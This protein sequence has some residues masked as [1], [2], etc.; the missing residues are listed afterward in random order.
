MAKRK[1]HSIRDSV[2]VDAAGILGIVFHPAMLLIGVTVCT[3][4]GSIHLWNQ[5]QS[6]IVQVE[7]F[8]LTPDK[9][10]INEQPPW[11]DQ[12]LEQ[13]LLE[14][15]LPETDRNLLNPSLIDRAVDVFRNAGW[16]EEVKRIEKNRNGL[17][18]QLKYRIPVALVELNRNTIRQWPLNKPERLFPVDRL[19]VIMSDALVQEIP[20]LRVTL[21]EPGHFTSLDPWTPWPDERVLEACQIADFIAADWEKLGFFRITTQ[22]LPSQPF[23]ENIPFELWTD[24]SMATKF[25]WGNPPGK[26]TPG[27]VAAV[28]K[29]KLLLELLE[30]YG[31]LNH[32]PPSKIDIRTG[33]PVTVEGKVAFSDDD[34]NLPRL[35]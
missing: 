15:V 25:V 27:E 32:L 16:V 5:H 34:P 28:E 20:L 19:G 7:D 3:I 21:F 29:L 1:P 2:S 26:E 31:P 4:A 13:R 17:D 18:I 23:D 9:I 6:L 22:R 24:Q 35:K 14:E 11:A 8:E 10:R 30:K 12:P 33:T